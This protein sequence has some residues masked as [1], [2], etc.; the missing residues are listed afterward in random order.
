MDALASFSA[1]GTTP[2]FA[3]GAGT[4]ALVVLL[5]VYYG[6]RI[7]RLQRELALLRVKSGEFTEKDIATVLGHAVSL[8][9]RGD[10][11]RAEALLRVIAEK[12]ADPGRV[13]LAKARLERL[14]NP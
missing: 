11:E 14:A 3:L 13:K 8:E 4:A 6:L 12:S 10:Y 5:R 7:R 2:L 9:V 1:D